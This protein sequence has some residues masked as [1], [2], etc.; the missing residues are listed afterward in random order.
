MLSFSSPNIKNVNNTQNTETTE[1]KK[2][3]YVEKNNMLNIANKHT[4]IFLYVNPYLGNT[5]STKIIK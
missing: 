4:D 3:E 2:V 1:V 5:S